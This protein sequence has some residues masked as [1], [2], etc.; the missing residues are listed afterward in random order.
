MGLAVVHGIVENHGGSIRVESQVGEGTTFKIFLPA[1][2]DT[3]TFDKESSEKLPGGAECILFVD[4]EESIARLGRL[5][6][7]RLGYQVEIETSP[8]KALEIFGA[9]PKQFDLV[10]TD[11]TM[12]AM[13][14][15]QFL[16]E[17]LQIRPDMPTILCTGF[18]EKIDEERA[19]NIGARA[20]AL[21]PLDRKDLAIIVRKVLDEKIQRNLSGSKWQWNFPVPFS[22]SAH[23]L[24]ACSELNP[25]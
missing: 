14:G 11:M 8:K 23:S 13:S 6:L 12:P 9:N 10:I 22:P 17:I 7:A 4:D 25:C 20:Y 24:S 2:Q 21:K 15:D 18:S 19:R 3:A 5:Q 1:T 16:R